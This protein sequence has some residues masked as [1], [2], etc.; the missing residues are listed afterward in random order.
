MPPGELVFAKKYQNESHAS[1][2]EVCQLFLEEAKKSSGDPPVPAA[3]CLACAGGISDNT[4]DFTNVAKG[5][6]IDG[7]QLQTTLGVPKVRLINDF[8]AQGYGLLTLS[9]KEV[10]QLNPNAE[11]V[12]GAPIACVGAGTGLGECYMTAD[13][14]SV[15]TCWPSEGGHAEF[16]P[17]SPLTGDLLNF[18]VKKFDKQG[19]KRVSMERVVS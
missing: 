1:F 4:V 18:L 9:A 10:I 13:E 12:P 19:R 2:T 14:R 6:K 8:V 7:Y 3:V 15:Y 11:A 16:S 17:R 5:W